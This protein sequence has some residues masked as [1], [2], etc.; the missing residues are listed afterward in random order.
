M[1][2]PIEITL[3]ID[4]DKHLAKH[5]GYDE[6]GDPIQSAATVEDV[7]L[8]MVAEK[9]VGSV[10]REGY[11]WRRVLQE[12]VNRVR[13]EAI[14]A[15]VLPDIEAALATPVRR[16]NSYGEPTGEPT[17]MRDVIVST[18]EKWLTSPSGDSYD[19][20]RLTKP[21]KFIAEHVDRVLQ[22]EMKVAVDA[23]KAEV[24]AAVQAKG[25]ELIAKTITDM[26][27]GR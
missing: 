1:A 5:I 16:T 17:S 27:A 25:A 9:I 24:L 12:R 11:D 13:D 19:R 26:A 8:D 20:N 15:R 3:S 21:Q 22:K 6:D 23:A 2:D 4:L 10:M 7:V 18:V 14:L